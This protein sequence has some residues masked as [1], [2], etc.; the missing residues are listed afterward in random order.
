MS[1][2]NKEDR[3]AHIPYPRDQ[4]NKPSTHPP[5]HL[6]IHPSIHPSVHHFD[7]IP[8]TSIQQSIY[9]TTL[10]K[11]Q[12]PAHPTVC[13][14]SHQYFLVNYTKD[15]YLPTHISECP[16]IFSQLHKRIRF[17]V[18]H[19]KKF[20]TFPTFFLLQILHLKSDIKS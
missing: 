2:H 6:S 1:S 7:T 17:S 15:F 3:I 19:M 9:L 11:Y 5:V 13:Q 20:E 14:S 18:T 10:Q 4:P 8:N 16:S 12:P